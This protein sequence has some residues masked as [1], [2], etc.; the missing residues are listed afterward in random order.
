MSKVRRTL[1]FNR[2]ETPKAREIEEALMH[3]LL[4]YKDIFANADGEIIVETSEDGHYS[5]FYEIDLRKLKIKD[6]SVWRH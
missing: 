4:A 5:E 6:T 2:A 1:E 3:I